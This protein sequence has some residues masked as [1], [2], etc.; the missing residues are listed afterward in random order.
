VKVDG[1]TI[2]AIY[3]RRGDLPIVRK[4]LLHERID[5]S[6]NGVG[7]PFLLDLGR[8]PYIGW[9]WSNPETWGTWSDGEKARIA[10]LLPEDKNLHSL[11]LE[12]ITITSPKHPEQKIE[13]LVNGAKQ[14][15][16]LL[17]GKEVQKINIPVP[18]LHQ[19]DGY[20]LIEFHFPDRKSPKELGQGVDER[21]LG[22]GIVGATFE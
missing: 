22:L 11:T 4:P 9:G 1:Q 18:K 3:R 6:A 15:D 14:K 16:V 19:H 5:F 10:M 17:S 2:A 13:I 21:K 7:R 12:A 8:S 20:L